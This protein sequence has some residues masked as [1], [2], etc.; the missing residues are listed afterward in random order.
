MFRFGWQVSES[1][2]KFDSVTCL[3][4]DLFH[5]FYGYQLELRVCV[6]PARSKAKQTAETYKELLANT[7]ADT[8]ESKVTYLSGFLSELSQLVESKPI[9]TPA[10]SFVLITKRVFDTFLLWFFS[11]FQEMFFFLTFDLH[12]ILTVQ[13]GS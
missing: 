11:N 4:L 1:K 6:L 10:R 2:W 7:H 9:Q 8:M 3:I 5:I 13:S 12:F